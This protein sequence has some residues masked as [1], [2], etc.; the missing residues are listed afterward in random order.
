MTDDQRMAFAHWSRVCRRV[1]DVQVTDRV[2]LGLSSLA[3]LAEALMS[4]D[5]MAIQERARVTLG[6]LDPSR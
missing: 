5:T 3:L 2:A 6:L 4:Q 1:E